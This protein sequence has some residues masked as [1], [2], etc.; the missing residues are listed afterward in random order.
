MKKKYCPKCGVYIYIY[1]YIYK[2]LVSVLSTYLMYPVLLVQRYKKKH[3]VLNVVY[4]YIYISIYTHIHI[5]IV[6]TVYVYN[7]SSSSN[8][9]EQKNRRR[10]AH[11]Y[12]TAI[13]KIMSFTDRRKGESQKRG[14]G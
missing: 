12:L 5:Y 3:T 13:L 9:K 6:R 8:K 4:I 11:I 10:A 7:V 1:I 14:K 2:Y